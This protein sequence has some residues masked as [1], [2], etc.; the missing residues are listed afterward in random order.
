MTSSNILWPRMI[1]K[2]FAHSLDTLHRI[3]RLTNFGLALCCLLLSARPSMAGES[4]PQSTRTWHYY[5]S[6]D[7][8]QSTLFFSG[9]FDVTAAPGTPSADPIKISDAFKQ[10]LVDEY[11]YD[12]D[13]VCFGNFKT[14]DAAQAGEQKRISDL[15]AAKKSKIVETGWIYKSASV[16]GSGPASAPAA[17]PAATTQG[18]GTGSAQGGS[19]QANSA[20]PTQNAPA[21]GTT[22]AVRML[23]AVDSGKDPAGKQYRGM[24]MKPADAGNGVTIP[25]GSLAMVTLM[26]NQGGWAAHLQSVMVKGQTVNVNSSSASVTGSAQNAATSAANTV[27][28]VIGG[29][30][31][32]GHKPP[33]PSGVEAVATGARVV[34]P[35]GTQMQFVL[36]ESPAASG[37]GAPSSMG[38]SVMGAPSAG[39]VPHPGGAIHPSGAMHPGGAGS[40]PAG[41]ASSS[42]VGQPVSAGALTANIK[43]TLLGPYTN[44]SIV[45]PDGG[46]YAVSAMHGSRSLMIVDG[47]DGPDFDHAAQTYSGSAI[48]FVF[49]ADGKHSCYIAQRGDDLVEVRDNKEAFVITSVKFE[50]GGSVPQIN[51]SAIWG[52][53]QRMVG[54]Q[55]LISPSG[56]HVAVVSTESHRPPGSQNS[57]HGEGTNTPAQQAAVI[58]ASAESGFHVFL[59]GVKSP[60]YR[61]IDLNQIAFAGEKLIYAAQTADQ[62]WHMV[63]NDQSGPAYDTVQSLL[64]NEDNK[65]Y[66]FITQASAGQQVVVD[67]VPGTVRGR[68][69]NGIQY[70]TIASNGRVAYVWDIPVTTGGRSASEALVVDDKE[71][72]PDI[73]PFALID[74]TG[75]GRS[76]TGYV[77]FSPDGKKFAY[78]KPVAGGIAAVIDGKVGRA[79]D[80]IGVMQFSPDSKHAFFVG[81]RALNFVV[82]DG[83]EMA[84]QNYIK[85]FCLQQRRWLLCL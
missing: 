36:G 16:S 12:G 67:G 23:E 13:A 61:L 54:H 30:G 42:A 15:R 38:A 22:L 63:V 14:T 82:V 50:I 65:H 80:N 70:L 3:A 76:M 62:K 7:Q 8:G 83:Q 64:V 35:P 52:P 58:A 72:C 31:G 41:A 40:H 43:E 45:S 68:A 48:D 59:D 75:Q 46:H 17:Q 55:C 81:N 56:A 77:I 2:S 57:G 11:G 78:A 71:V 60:L 84:G 26:K 37:G 53:G 6:S 28:S 29:F 39:G 25:Q 69:G 44:N 51:Q 10:S 19:T 85:N 32:F 49:N 73:R 20:A 24:V 4:N 79:Y 1:V 27:T 66:A 21:A 74:E 47:V 34:L 33:K 9:A 18:A 5:C